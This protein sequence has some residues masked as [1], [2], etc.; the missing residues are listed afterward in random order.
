MM[1]GKA[2]ELGTKRRLDMLGIGGI[3]LFFSFTRPYLCP[4]TQVSLA[5]LC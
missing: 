3:E 2:E 1:D 4:Q 5:A